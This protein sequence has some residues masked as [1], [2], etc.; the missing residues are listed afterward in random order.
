MFQ[1]L[2]RTAKRPMTNKNS[3]LLASFKRKL[4]EPKPFNGSGHRRT[5]SMNFHEPERQITIYSKFNR[6]PRAVADDSDTIKGKLRAEKEKQKEQILH[7]QRV[8][9]STLNLF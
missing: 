2:Q 6:R 5:L 8:L 4:L 7:I 9:D 3:P 1:Y